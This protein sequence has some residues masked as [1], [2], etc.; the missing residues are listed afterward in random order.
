MVGIYTYT[1]LFLYNT[2][3]FIF[4]SYQYTDENTIP[5]LNNAIKTTITSMHNQIDSF[6]PNFSKQSFSIMKNVI[7]QLNDKYTEEEKSIQC[8]PQNH[9]I[10]EN[11][12]TAYVCSN[13]KTLQFH[14]EQDASYTV[15]GV[16]YFTD[17]VLCGLDDYK[18]QFQWKVGQ[19]DL[20]GVDI[21]LIPGT[22]LA[23]S[24]MLI[25]HRQ[26]LDCDNKGSFLNLSSY[27][28]S[29][30]LCNMLAKIK[31]SSKTN[32]INLMIKI[33]SIKY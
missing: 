12:C 10:N 29:K 19:N 16:P 14:R 9:M 5:Y 4:V 33:I 26:V 7:Q 23:Y 18:F 1:V 30:I 22:V 15:I 20:D 32:Y 21:K 24:G 3:C 8:I 27:H 6:L 28:N 11:C 2:S 25:S 17:E 13:A 31:K